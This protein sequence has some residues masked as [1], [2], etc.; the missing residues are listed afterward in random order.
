MGAEETANIL[1][2]VTGGFHGRDGQ[3]K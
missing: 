1:P 2:D 3:S